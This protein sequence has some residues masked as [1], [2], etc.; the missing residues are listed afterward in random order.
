LY[1]AIKSSSRFGKKFCLAMPGRIST[2]QGDCKF[3]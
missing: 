1:H 2:P 3:S